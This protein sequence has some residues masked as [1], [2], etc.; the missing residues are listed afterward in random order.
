VTSTTVKHFHSGITTAASLTGAAGSLISVLDACLVTGFGQV[1]VDSIAIASGVATATISAGHSFGV[2]GIVL[3]AGSGISDLN[4]EQRVLTATT[5][6]IT[7]ATTASD[8]TV[9]GTIT[10]KWAP[11]GWTKVLSGTNVAVYQ[12]ADVTSARPFLRVDDSG[13]T[14]ARA[15]GYEAMTDVSTGTN[16]FPTTAQIS[17]GLYWH[18]ATAAGTNARAWTLVGD[19]KTFYLHMQT[20][21]SG[22]GASGGVWM[23]GDVQADRSGDAYAAAIVGSLTSGNYTSTSNN[24]D[25]VEYSDSG[26]S[27][28]GGYAMRSYNGLGGSVNLGSTVLG[29]AGLSGAAAAY[30]W[31]GGYPNRADN[32]LPL[33]RKYVH[34]YGVTSRGR[35]R[36]ALFPLVV[37]HSAFAWKDKVDGQGDYVGRKLLAVKCGV[38]AGTGSAGVMFFD[39]TGPWE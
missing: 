28:R 36:G 38:I 24:T 19:S 17:G 35:M 5:N 4:G 23:F 11:L 39:I 21:T 16:A 3:I 31:T 12:S 18:K 27:T 20:T 37:C 6:T 26:S 7:F 33:A 14:S 1:S 13:S 8:Q 15:V 32:G 22:D 9:T 30:P 25:G 10:A 34:E 2:D 29:V